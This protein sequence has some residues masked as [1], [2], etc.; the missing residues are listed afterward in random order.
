M[1]ATDGPIPQIDT[2]RREPREGSQAADEDIEQIND[3]ISVL[4]DK[5]GRLEKAYKKVS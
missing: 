4:K 1:S 2:S 3:L 5:R